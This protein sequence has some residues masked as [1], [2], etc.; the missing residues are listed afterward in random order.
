M[1]LKEKT[2]PQKPEKNQKTKGVLKNLYTFFQ[3][4]GRVL[5]VF[6]SKIFPTKIEG[7]VTPKQMFQRLTI[8]LAQ[9]KT[10]NTYEQLLNEIR[11]IIYK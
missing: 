3:G 7:M 6:E 5:D 1:N 11:K 10:D 8:A 2:K 4:R 9:V